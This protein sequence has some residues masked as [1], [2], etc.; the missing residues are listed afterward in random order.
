M[1]AGKIEEEQPGT[2]DDE[3]KGEQRD[4]VRKKLT[5]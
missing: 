3:V 1:L 2:V 4:M 5:R